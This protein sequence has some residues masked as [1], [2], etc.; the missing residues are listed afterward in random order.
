MER[1]KDTSG[2]T[3]RHTSSHVHYQVIVFSG[4]M[5]TFLRIE[6]LSLNYVTYSLVIRYNI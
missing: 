2:K 3:E 6:Q 1:D 4:T 5:L